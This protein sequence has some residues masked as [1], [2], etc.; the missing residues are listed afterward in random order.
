MIAKFISFVV[1]L[2]LPTILYMIW[3]AVLRSRR[4]KVPATGWRSWPWAYLIGGGLALASAVTVSVGLITADPD[5]GTYVPPHMEDGK[6]VPGEFVP[7]GKA[8]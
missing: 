7:E 8:E 1:P 2:L 3:V 6:L 4:G 5:R